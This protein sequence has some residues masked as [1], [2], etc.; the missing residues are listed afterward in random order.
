M[1]GIPF[2]FIWKGERIR[3]GSR[4]CAEL[5]RRKEEME[6]KAEEEARRW[7]TRRSGSGSGKV[8]GV[9]VP[10]KVKVKVVGREHV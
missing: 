10:E 4:F 6:R 8:G 2:V 7:R 9:A 1:C 5:K 3:A